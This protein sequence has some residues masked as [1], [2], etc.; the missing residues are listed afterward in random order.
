MAESKGRSP[1]H[2]VFEIAEEK[3]KAEEVELRQLTV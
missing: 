3:A 1:G 2:W